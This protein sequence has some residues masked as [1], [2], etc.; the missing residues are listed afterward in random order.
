[1]DRKWISIFIL[2]AIF[3]ISYSAVSYDSNSWIEI[4][5]PKNGIYIFDT[6]I[7]PIKGQIVFGAVTVEAE[8]GDEI[9]EIEFIVPPK[10]GC[11]GV[12]IY[13]ANERPFS[14][15]WDFV[16]PGLKDTGMV[17]FKARGYKNGEYMG[18]DNIF[19]WRFMLD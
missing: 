5:R 10:V 12:V 9:D 13:N 15:Y 4:K 17:A 8:G 18:E 7:M 14:F 2:T 16:H 6:K 3:I 19:I 1:M 11:R